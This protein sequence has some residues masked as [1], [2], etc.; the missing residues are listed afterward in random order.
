MKFK[1]LP[2]GSTIEAERFTIKNYTNIKQ[3][4]QDHLEDGL[5]M[6]KISFKLSSYYDIFKKKKYKLLIT[7]VSSYHIVLDEGNWLG[8]IGKTY[9]NIQDSDMIIYYEEIK[10]TRRSKSKCNT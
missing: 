5:C 7:F 4:I 1:Y 3:F 6:N 2:D 10:N 9:Y 8:L